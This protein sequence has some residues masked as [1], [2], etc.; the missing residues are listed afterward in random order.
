MSKRIT[1]KAASHVAFGHPLQDLPTS[2]LPTRLDVA[3]H[4]LFL[5]D[6][7]SSS[8]KDVIPQLSQALIDV[9][10]RAGIPPQ[11]LKNVKMK[12]MRLMDDGSEV[13]KHGISV[14][15]SKKFMDSLNELFD[16][17]ACQCKDLLTCNCAKELKIP[18]R[19]RDF[20]VD[21]R[22]A[23]RMQIGGVDKA[24]TEMMNRSSSRKYRFEERVADEKKIRIEQ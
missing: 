1:R 22:T 20:I 4:F 12:L 18:A 2:E 15:K 24:V 19:E 7:K 9:W 21:Q 3:R 17:A 13:S 8:N 23:R 10:I 16:I 5:K 6:K 14:E 11:P